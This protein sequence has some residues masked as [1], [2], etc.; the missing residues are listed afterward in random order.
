MH[1]CYT[2][3]LIFLIFAAFPSPIMEAAFGRL[4]NG[5]PA[6]F[7]RRPTVVESIMGDG[8]VANISKN[9]QIH[10]KYVHVLRILSIL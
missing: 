3:L 6:A 5:G 9:K 1:I 2:Y 8:K 7:S 4:H 10:I